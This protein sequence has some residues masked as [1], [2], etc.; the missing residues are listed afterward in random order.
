MSD[1][2][3]AETI[4]IT[5][6]EGAEI[7]AYVARPLG[8]D[9]HGSVILIHH[10]PGYDAATK[11]MA[12]RFATMGYAALLPN[13]YS[14]QAPGREPG[15]AAAVVR[16]QGGVPDE[17]LIGDVAG[18]AAA[19]RRL[20]ASNGKVGCIGHCSGGRQSFLAACSVD[21][22]AAVDC[23][24]AFVVGTLPDGFPLRVEPLY[25]RI[26]DL[27]CPVLGLFGADDQHPS[28]EDDH[29]LERLCA[30]HGKDF[31]MK[32]YDGA[33]H[34]FFFTGRDSYRADAAIDGWARIE[35]FF[36]RHLTT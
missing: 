4:R 33:S 22:D 23:Y 32:I 11:E 9:R 25:D 30:R 21:L 2:V 35:E 28:V 34:A 26:P 13:L 17:Q 29:E 24:G 31:S 6:H 15:E 5:G 18:A 12:R 20:P 16:E 3:L 14:R 27:R 7:E 19:L 36:G 8:V 1:T 10:L